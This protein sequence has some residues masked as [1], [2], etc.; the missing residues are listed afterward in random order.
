MKYFLIVL[1]VI[2][3]TLA[4]F[5]IFNPLELKYRQTPEYVTIKVDPDSLASKDSRRQKGDEQ[6]RSEIAVLKSQQAVLDAQL[7]AYNKRIDDIFIFG[8][9]II[10]LLLAIIASIY[11]KAEH[12]VENH[13]KKN[14]ESYRTRSLAVLNEVQQFST[15][16]K[17]Q[18]GI[19]QT[20]AKET[21]EK[22]ISTAQEAA[23][24]SSNEQQPANPEQGTDSAQQN[25][26][27]DH[28]DEGSKATDENDPK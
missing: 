21:L 23:G 17:T 14:F 5:S 9:I 28:S 6:W 4:L 18:I 2:G 7:T 1:M 16:A 27:G 15:T 19:M 11:I 26:N 10:T 20:W 13:F 22:L 24:K 25:E 3:F 8:G 12:D